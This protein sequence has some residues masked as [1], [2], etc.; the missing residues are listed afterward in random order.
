MVATAW[1]SLLA[2]NS[3]CSHP[4][5]QVLSTA[6]SLS[7]AHTRSRLAGSCTSPVIVIAIRFSVVVDVLLGVGR[8]GGKPSGCDMGLRHQNGAGSNRH[9]SRDV[10]IGCRWFLMQASRAGSILQTPFGGLADG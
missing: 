8:P 6:G 9:C 5:I 2:F 4:G 10:F 1:N 3:S 7:I